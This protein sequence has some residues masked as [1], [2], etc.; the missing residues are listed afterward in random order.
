MCIFQKQAPRAMLRG[1]TTQRHGQAGTWDGGEGNLCTQKALSQQ[2]LGEQLNL[3][4]TAS[5]E[6]VLVF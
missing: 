2:L 3:I 5:C 1:V 4:F 6:L